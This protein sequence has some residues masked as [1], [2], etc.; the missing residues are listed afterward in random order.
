MRAFSIIK[1]LDSLIG[2]FF[3]FALRR[4][5]KWTTRKNCKTKKILLIKFGNIG[6]VLITIP[7][8]RA[9]RQKFPKAEITMLTTPRTCGLYE[10]YSYIDKVINAGLTEDK[11][12]TSNIFSTIIGTFSLA[13]KIRKENFDL[14]VDFET[15]SSFSACLS[16]FSG[17]GTR[18]GIVFKGSS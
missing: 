17:A 11:N 13:R 15:Y 12:I 5:G 18:A 1:K 4:L 6:D 14:V 3:I 7:S 16:F 10:Q 2:P 9:I 8:I